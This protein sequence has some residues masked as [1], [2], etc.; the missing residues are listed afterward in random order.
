VRGRLATAGG[1]REEALASVAEGLALADMGDFYELRVLSRLAFARLLLDAGRL[2]EARGRAEEVIDLAQVR[3]DV[4]YEG[5][6]RDLLGRTSVAE[7]DHGAF[8]SR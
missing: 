3:G 4:I 5:R 2:E 1:R 8:N 6:A 7:S